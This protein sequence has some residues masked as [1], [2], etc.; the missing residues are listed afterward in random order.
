MFAPL[1]ARAKAR[2]G[3]VNTSA[4]KRSTLLRHQVGSA[5]EHGF[6]RQRTVGNQAELPLLSRSHDQPADRAEVKPSSSASWDF[7]KI[8]LF[9]SDRSGPLTNI[10]PM[11]PHN[12]AFGVD[13]AAYDEPTAVPEEPESLE[14]C[15]DRM[16]AVVGI[17]TRGQS[18]LN[19]GSPGD[20]SEQDADRAAKNACDAAEGGH[21]NCPTCADGALPAQDAYTYT[22]IEPRGSYGHTDANFTR[23]S[24]RASGT[25]ATIAAGSAAPTTHVYATGTYR[26]RRNDGVVKNARCTRLAAGRAATQAHE[27]SHAAGAR[28]AVAAANNA[29]GLPREFLAA[30]AQCTAALPAVLAAWNTSVDAAWANETNHG[31]GTS[32]PTATTF[33]QENAAGTCTFT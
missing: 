23:P 16:R 32:P 31:P 26:V 10:R 33:A 20:Q 1:I 12:S 8:P 28:A 25:G 18:K 27:N 13:V 22:V 24:C 6:M 15:G 14:P 7:S 30:P 2:S 11:D 17:S 4:P 21:C 19:V 3:R 29:Q 5:A 9:P